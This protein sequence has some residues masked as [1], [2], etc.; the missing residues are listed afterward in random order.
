MDAERNVAINSSEAVASQSV[1]AE[2]NQVAAN[3]VVITTDEFGKALFTASQSGQY[4]VSS[5]IDVSRVISGLVTGVPNLP[6][7]SVKCTV[8][9]NPFTGSINVNCPSPISSV[10]IFNVE[11][12]LVFME[13]EPSQEVNLEHLPSGLY[14][15]RIKSGKQVFQQKIVKK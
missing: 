1:I 2:P 11:G 15:I 4:L 5:G 8:F 13:K 7:V 12:L 10:E 6:E 14:I 3:R 9:P